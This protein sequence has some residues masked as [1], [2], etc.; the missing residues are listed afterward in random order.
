VD[1]CEYSG[2]STNRNWK[3]VWKLPSSRTQKPT[4]KTVHA[5]MYEG[6]LGSL[7]NIQFGYNEVI[8]YVR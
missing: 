2:A 6:L 7:F 4:D 3:D 8:N 5:G 1:E